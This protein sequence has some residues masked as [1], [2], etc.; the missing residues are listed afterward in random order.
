MKA[1]L[2]KVAPK[3]V[4]AEAPT[5]SFIQRMAVGVGRTVAST[6]NLGTDVKVGYQYQR[7]LDKGEL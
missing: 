6:I 4:K 7:A 2:A 1:S 3:A 5:E